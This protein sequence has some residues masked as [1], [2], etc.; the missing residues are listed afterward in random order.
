MTLPQVKASL[1][2]CKRRE[3]AASMAMMNVVHAAMAPIMVGPKGKSAFDRLWNTL[4]RVIFPD[5][6]AEVD[7]DN[8]FAHFTKPTNTAGVAEPTN[9]ELAALGIAPVIKLP[10][11]HKKAG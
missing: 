1:E 3:A 6:H 9:E 10:P 11:Q 5:A 2:A 4:R 8:P 7:R